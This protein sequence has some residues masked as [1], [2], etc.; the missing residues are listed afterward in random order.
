MS[1]LFRAGVLA[2]ALAFTLGS[3]LIT[4]GA[5]ANTPQID[6]GSDTGHYVNDGECD[7]ARF[8]GPGSGMA[9]R[10]GSDAT[11]CRAL[12]AAGQITLKAPVNA[13]LERPDFGNDSGDYTLD[14]ECDDPRFEGPLT[15]TAGA[16]GTDASDCRALWDAGLIAPRARLNEGVPAP[17]FGSDTGNHVNDGECDDPRFMGPL[18]SSLGD[19][20]TDATDCA[21]AW[22]AGLITLDPD[23]DPEARARAAMVVVFDGIE[24]GN[25]TSQ[26]AND[27]ECDDPRFEGP[28]A[29]GLGRPG[30]DGNDC[31]AAWQA[32]EVT[33]KP[34]VNAGL[35]LPD[36]GD[37]S[38]NFALD[39]E[40]DDPRFEGPM[41]TTA[42][43]PGT[44]ASDCR[45][46]WDMGLI[47]PRA[48]LNEGL[49]EPDFGDDSG[50]FT[51]DG[52]CD[53]TRFTGPGASGVGDPLTD[54]SD[55]AAA[56][57]AGTITLAPSEE[58]AVSPRL[59]STG[60]GF[61]I[62]GAGHVLTNAH[63]IEGCPVLRS[64]T[65]GRLNLL[66]MDSGSDL[67]LLQA[68]TPTASFAA[69]S[70]QSSA[71]LGEEI[72][73]AGF[74]LNDF[75][76]K[77]SVTISTGTISSRTGLRDDAKVFQISAPVQY[78]N[79]GGPVFNRKGEVVGVV[80]SKLDSMAVFE[81]TKD[82]PQNINFAV[83]LSAIN[84]FLASNPV[85]V[86]RSSSLQVESL[87]DVAEH[88]ESVTGL[89][90]CLNAAPEPLSA[91]VLAARSHIETIDFGD[92]S[93]QWTLD[94]ECDDPRFTGPGA[95]S[96]GHPGSDATDCRR[97]WTE[98]TITQ[99]PD[100]DWDAFARSRENVVFDGIDFGNNTG[101]WAHDGEC[102]DPR[103]AGNG[104]A[105][106]LVDADRLRDASDCRALYEAGQIRL[107]E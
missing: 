45:A 31:L 88:A 15:S 71:R 91:E 66:A 64:P 87:A 37:D 93:G 55:C 8:E 85:T 74:P 102:D 25:N 47:T 18:A 57:A 82:L 90:E 52:E 105:E 83:S 34:P 106:V 89:I 86:S 23:F 101:M 39:G 43:A 40:C 12:W 103:F 38:G 27:G 9:G 24:F 84:D 2:T 29:S 19:P 67:A 97:A 78:G 1:A 80:V 53:D 61:A 7:D 41:T 107:R 48:R 46:L 49:P 4:P 32:G 20:G 30:M 96:V 77:Q 65:F 100:F 69:I 63:V 36:F 73:A 11:D 59:L 72:V 3:G 68:S 50:Q 17:E 22:A 75:L 16:P 95:S 14:G 5:L 21:A 76:K 44:D 10:I 13:G 94:W 99:N 58:L 26:W 104:M 92:D 79:S 70:G 51:F 6:F 33:L 42:G 28:N 60:T 81:A 98:G 56:W 54:A 62:S 35:P